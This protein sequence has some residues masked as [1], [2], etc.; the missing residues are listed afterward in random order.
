MYQSTDKLVPNEQGVGKSDYQAIEGGTGGGGN[1]AVPQSFLS[2][3]KKA[4]EENIGCCSFCL[5]FFALL[6]GSLVWTLVIIVI[7]TVPIVMIVIG[8]EYFHDCPAQKMI[9]ISL[10]VAGCVAMLSNVINF[11]DRF[12]RLSETGIPKRHTV[13]GWINLVLNLFMLGWFLATCYWVY[14]ANGADF[15]DPKSLTYCNPRMYGFVFWFINFIWIFFGT[16]VVISAFVMC[17]A[18]MC[19]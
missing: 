7:I 2:Q 18:L 10:I 4:K 11:V 6:I 19:W 8:A 1:E 5:A 13:I 16:M 17:F 3:V 9:P 14:N 15:Q 12:K